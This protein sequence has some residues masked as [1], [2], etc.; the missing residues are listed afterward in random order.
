V[1]LKGSRE[2]FGL[3]NKI[4]EGKNIE[5]ALPSENSIVE[6]TPA[7]KDVMKKSVSMSL[8]LQRLQK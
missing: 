2:V 3:N 8:N 5:D 4:L 6:K 1:K 7:V